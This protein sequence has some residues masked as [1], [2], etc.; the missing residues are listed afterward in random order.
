[1]A[2]GWM[3]SLRCSSTPTSWSIEQFARRCKTRKS[4]LFPP[5]PESSPPSSAFALVGNCRP[6]AFPVFDSTQ[7]AIFRYLGLGFSAHGSLPQPGLSPSR[8]RRQAIVPRSAICSSTFP[9]TSRT[10]SGSSASQSVCDASPF[11]WTGCLHHLLR[12]CLLRWE[13]SR[14][15]AALSTWGFPHLHHGKYLNRLG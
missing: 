8:A 15:R 14:G 5:L 2:R 10:A 11:C 9:S 12:H 6:F 7:R 3:T 4:H 1:M 13:H